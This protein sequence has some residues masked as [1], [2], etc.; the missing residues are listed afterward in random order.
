MKQNDGWKFAGYHEVP[1]KYY[2]RRHEM[3]RFADKPFL[4][5]SVQGASGTGVASE[6]AEWFDLTLPVFEPVF[7][8]P[9]QGQR[10]MTDLD[11]SRGV[12]GYA[13]QHQ[14]GS[15]ETIHLGLSVRFSFDGND[16]GELTTPAAARPPDTPAF[17]EA[18]Q[19]HRRDEAHCEDRTDNRSDSD[20]GD[21]SPPVQFSVGTRSMWSIT[22]TSTVA[23]AAP[24]SILGN[25]EWRQRGRLCELEPFG[26]PTRRIAPARGMR[27]SDFTLKA[28]NR[29]R[30]AIDVSQRRGSTGKG[31][32]RVVWRV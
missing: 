17:A 24:A 28:S 31:E 13:S 3:M 8:F 27:W 9:V 22:T 23:C 7:S 14:V 26:P 2:P 16:L 15:V 20:G 18:H 5:I 29:R 19:R 11:I 4:E 21:C 6:I 30:F 12:S 32:Y 10:H 25:L 1:L